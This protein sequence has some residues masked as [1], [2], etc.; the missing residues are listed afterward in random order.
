M[1][2]GNS[3]ERFERDTAEHQMTVRHDDGLYRHLRCQRPGSWTYGFDIVT[4]PG[5]LAVTGD[6]GDFTFART[7]DMFEFFR[8]DGGRIN[9]D[10]WSEKLKGPGP[11]HS[12]VMDFDER[13]YHAYV[14]EHGLDIVDDWGGPH[15]KHDACRLLVEAGVD[16]FD[17][18]SMERYSVQFLWCCHAILW[19]I[20]QYDR[21]GVAHG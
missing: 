17:L 19:A 18:P 15:N 7:A 5:Y 21:A 4:W 14:Q 3:R 11:A 6:M 8:V 20:D 10:Y 12:A 16:P 9:P 2:E 13:A 1:T